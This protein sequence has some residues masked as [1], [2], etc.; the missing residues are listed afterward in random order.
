M[1]RGS[2]THGPVPGSRRQPACAPGRSFHRRRWL[3]MSQLTA[4]CLPEMRV[5]RSKSGNVLGEGLVWCDRAQALYWTDIQRSHAVSACT[6]PVRDARALGRCPSAWPRSH[7][8]RG[9]WLAA[10]GAGV[11]TGL[12]PPFRRSSAGTAAPGRTVDL[13]TRCNDGACD[14]QGRFVFGT[15]HEPESRREP[16]SRSA[17]FW[18]LARRSFT[19]ERLELPGVAI[20]NSIAFSPAGGTHV[21]L[22]FAASRRILVAASYGDTLGRAAACSPIWVISRRRTLMA[23]ASMPMATCGTHNG[24]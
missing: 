15:L 2:G 7:C 14:R 10:A 1:A 19:L 20:S 8:V 16:D 23:P 4:W 12:L 5:T 6:R 22:R 11:A 24:D 13:P 18:R 3:G 17:A 21:L 9:G